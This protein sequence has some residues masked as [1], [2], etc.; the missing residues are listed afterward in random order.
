MRE[1]QCMLR[2]EVEEVGLDMLS[3]TCPE[4][5][6]EEIK[7]AVGCDCGSQRD[8]LWRQELG[9]RHHRTCSFHSVSS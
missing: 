2:W 4:T 5:S 6:E 8:Q 9:S 1:D 7:E 3:V